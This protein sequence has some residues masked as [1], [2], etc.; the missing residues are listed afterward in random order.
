[1]KK[2]R[3]HELREHVFFHTKR[4]GKTHRTTPFNSHLDLPVMTVYQSDFFSKNSDKKNPF[5][6]V[7][8]EQLITQIKIADHDVYL[9]SLLALADDC[10]AYQ[11]RL[12]K[13][14]NE[15][16]NKQEAFPELNNAIISFICKPSENYFLHGFFAALQ[17]ASDEY[18]SEIFA[19]DGFKRFS[20]QLSIKQA[21]EFS[22]QTRNIQHQDS[23]FTEHFKDMS[24]RVDEA[25][26]PVI[27]AGKLGV[28]QRQQIN[29]FSGLLGYL[30]DGL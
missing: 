23:R 16:N 5:N 17:K 10:V 22:Y 19:F 3:E 28:L 1:M 9:E 15:S 7:Q 2:A 20:Q 18:I 4:S 14:S 21:A 8:I 6:E 25:K 24:Y 12:T 13:G 27:N 30:P 29:K 26:A 11:L